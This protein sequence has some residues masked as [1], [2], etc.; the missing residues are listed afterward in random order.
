[1]EATPIQTKDVLSRAL[2]PPFSDIQFWIIQIVVVFLTVLHFVLDATHLTASETLIGLPV[3]A[4]LIPVGWAAMRFGLHGSGATALWS[5]V[6]WLP[7]LAF[8]HGDDNLLNELIALFIVDLVGFVFGQHVEHQQMTKNAAIAIEAEQ[9]A[10]EARYRH[11]F[12]ATRAPILVVDNDS[13]VVDA[14][15]A[16][17]A[18]FGYSVLDENVENVLGCSLLELENFEVG[19]VLTVD[20]DNEPTDFRCLTTSVRDQDRLLT[21]VLL[22]DITEERRAW[23]DVTTYAATL[24]KAQ[25][26]ERSR[27]ARELHDDPLQSLLIISRKLESSIDE[28]LLEIELD[29]TLSEE[30]SQVKGDV[31]SVAKT[32]R[33]LSQGLLPPSLEKLGLEPA[34][35]GLVADGEFNSECKIDLRVNGVP[36]RLQLDHEL[37]LFRICQEAIHNAISHAKPSQIEVTLEFGD[38]MLALEIVDDGCGIDFG[39]EIDIS[40]LGLRGMRERASL[41]G[42][43]LMI[44]SEVAKGTKIS[45]SIPTR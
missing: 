14:N 13:V 26:D 41:L 30:L 37:G 6:L 44:E 35:R 29:D 19:E 34:L 8:H 33:N 4:L 25:E 31:L 17:W 38:S 36:S 3:F 5:T 18:V 12:S 43:R 39:K 11:L 27:I 1:M 10:G 21:Q 28:H 9:R 23:R 32:I 20:V 7:D 40:H 45:L 24:L 2:H 15:P 22:Q 16:A 42:G